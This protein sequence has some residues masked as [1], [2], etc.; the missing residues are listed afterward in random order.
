MYVCMYGVLT[1]SWKSWNFQIS[2]IRLEGVQA[3]A[4]VRTWS[5]RVPGCPGASAK[6][7]AASDG[8]IP[9]NH[10]H[11]GSVVWQICIYQWKSMKFIEKSRVG[12]LYIWNPK[13]DTKYW[14][15]S[16]IQKMSKTSARLV[17]CPIVP[18][19]IIG[20]QIS[21]FSTSFFPRRNFLQISDF[22]VSKKKWSFQFLPQCP[23]PSIAPNV[24]Q[25]P[26]PQQRC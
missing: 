5:G 8:V 12:H 26:I 19:L 17:L 14:K 24:P 1:K 2:E 6:L 10:R 25:G 9:P 15:F 21:D 7:S 18:F 22:R 16:K 3:C 11:L 23:I 20:P 4:G 13:Y